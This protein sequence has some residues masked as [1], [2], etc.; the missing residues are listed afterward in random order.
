M[1]RRFEAVW[2]MHLIINEVDRR[3]NSGLLLL[4]RL[5]EAAHVIVCRSDIRIEWNAILLKPISKLK[6]IH[7]RQ[8]SIVI[9]R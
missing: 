3:L 2:I 9:R 1:Q 5:I 4:R 6:F 8:L 7:H